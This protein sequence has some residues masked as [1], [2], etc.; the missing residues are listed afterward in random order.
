MLTSHVPCAPDQRLIRPDMGQKTSIFVLTVLVLG[1]AF[2]GASTLFVRLSDLGPIASAFQRAFL[3]IPA[4]WLLMQWERR[5]N[6]SPDGMV[7]PDRRTYQIL[8]LAGVFFA[9]D[10]FFW[11]LAIMNTTVA[12]ATLLAT[13]A[14]IY[15]TGGMFLLFGERPTPIFLAG[16]GLA[17]IGAGFLIGDSIS[18]RPERLDGDIYGVI[19]GFFL[20]GY[21][22]TISRLRSNLSTGTVMYYSTLATAAVLFPLALYFDGNLL[23]ASLEGWVVLLTLALVSHVGGQGMVAYAMAHLPAAFT[24]VTLI[25]EVVSAALLGWLFLAES[26]G[27]WQWVGAGIIVLGIGAAR[28]GS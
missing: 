26:L 18:Y 10:L 16:V 12:N 5:R 25:L 11:H 17:V 6:S 3:A 15:V 28:R 8:A 27:F 2:A 22:I 20:A 4:L 24:S 7:R 19:T 23:S 21:L 1:A 13:L 9:G 14:P